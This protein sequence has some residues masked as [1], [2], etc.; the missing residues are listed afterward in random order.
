MDG[1]S[2]RLKQSNIQGEVGM[3]A[4]KK[5]KRKQSRGRRW[6]TS[7]RVWEG[8]KKKKNISPSNPS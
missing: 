4:R 7:E 5:E 1:E 8:E 6:W 2:K 3:M